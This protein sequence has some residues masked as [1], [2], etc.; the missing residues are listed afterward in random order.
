MIVINVDLKVNEAKREEYLKFVANLVEKSR[1]DLG[2]LFYSHFEDVAE[3]NK[4]IIVE[5]WSNEES[6]EFH[7][8]TEH[9]QAF[10]KHVNQYLVE[11]YVIKVAKTEA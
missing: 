8:Q 7:N 1:H 5:N 4:F 6:L 10:L 11:D 2:N 9:L 3:R